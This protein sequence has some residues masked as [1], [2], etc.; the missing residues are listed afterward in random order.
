MKEIERVIW[1]VLD[2][3]G[4]GAMPDAGRFGDE[5]CN[6]IGHVSKANG[7]LNLPNMIKLGYGNID[8]MTGIGHCDNPM[9]CF[10][11]L[12]EI[13][14][15]KDTTTGHWEM[16]GIHTTQAFPVYPD[17][18]PEDII[19]KFCAECE[20]KGVLG[21]KPASGTV[22]LEE[23]GEEHERTGKPIVYTS[24][25]SVFQIAAHEEVIPLERL[26]EMCQKARAILDGEHKVARVIARPFVGSKGNYVRTAN[27]RDFSIKPDSNNL[28]VKLQEKNVP[29]IGIGKIEDI[30]CGVGISKAIHTKDNMD[31]V[32]VTLKCMEEEEKGLIF[33]NLVE[34][35]SKWGH[36]NDAAGYAKG[37][38]EWDARLPEIL[39]KMTDKDLLIITADHGCD[40]TTPGTDHTREYVPLVL[41]GKG[42]RQNINL[43][44][45]ESF[46]SIGQ[47]VSDIFGAGKLA[48]GE[49]LLPRIR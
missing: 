31:G 40:P 29:V 5:G 17:G 19:G 2:S 30:F 49:D 14:N 36:R 22:I 46:A 37:L 47:T 45:I 16:V 38:E 48:I 11:R 12:S 39:S 32:D 15:G 28:L 34:F 6:T 23:L 27:R 42:I 1:V 26:Y 21:N 9:G 7:G 10:G 13:S 44:T 33:T 25:D 35:D 4:M 24:A 43:G 41:Y 8:G 18:F 3:V 20:I